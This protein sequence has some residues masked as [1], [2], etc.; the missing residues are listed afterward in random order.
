[1]LKVVYDN[2]PIDDA[3]PE[4]FDEIRERLNSEWK[5][6]PKKCDVISDGLKKKCKDILEKHKIYMQELKK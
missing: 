2:G 4:T 5:K 1:M 6:L 3:F